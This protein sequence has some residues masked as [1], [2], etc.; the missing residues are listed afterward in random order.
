MKWVVFAAAALGWTV[1]VATAAAAPGQGGGA[2][3]LIR[4]WK[5]PMLLGQGE[6]KEG[7]AEIS[8]ASEFA[9]LMSPVVGAHL[10]Q[11]CDEMVRAWPGFAQR[12]PAGT[13]PGRVV[14]KVRLKRDGAVE[15]I[16][17]VEGREH[18]ALAAAAKA[19]LKSLNGKIKPF[20]QELRALVGSVIEEHVVFFHL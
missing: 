14:M 12:I 16:E 5:A 13:P 2:T 3:T 15:D 10:R 19:C 20:S 9:R 8:R 7:E 18:A 1:A 6:K 11:F 4:A 17:C